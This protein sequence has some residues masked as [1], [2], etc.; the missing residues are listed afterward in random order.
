MPQVKSKPDTDL[1][2]DLDVLISE[3]QSSH[4]AQGAFLEQLVQTRKRLAGVRP[5]QWDAELYRVAT[6]ATRMLAE[7]SAGILPMRDGSPPVKPASTMSVLVRASTGKKYRKTKKLKI[8]KGTP[9]PTGASFLKKAFGTKEAPSR[10][11]DALCQVYGTTWPDSKV[12]VLR[13]GAKGMES[14]PVRIEDDLHAPKGGFLRASI[15]QALVQISKAHMGESV[16]RVTANLY[17][18][19]TQHHTMATVSKLVNQWLSEVI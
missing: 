7:I 18:E 19:V 16:P 1:L 9:Q 13:R 4:A 15:H 6:D 3:L 2:H 12:H 11:V 8:K 5:G 10:F 14:Q 17:Q